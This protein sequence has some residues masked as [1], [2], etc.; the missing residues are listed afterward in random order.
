M[1]PILNK[2]CD[3][4]ISYDFS[5]L[6]K[7]K[8]FK[9]IWQFALDK[10]MPI[11]LMNIPTTYPAQSVDGF[12]ISGGGGGIF[13]GGLPENSVY[14]D[15]AKDVLIKNNYI[16]DVRLGKQSSNF[17]SITAY[18]DELERMMKSRTN[19]YIELA[20]QHSIGFGFLAYRA[21]TSLLYLA[22]SEIMK[23]LDQTHASSFK[24]LATFEW[25]DLVYNHFR[26][27]DE[28]LKSLFDNLQPKNFI[29]TSD[30]SIYL[31]HII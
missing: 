12:Y 1:H 11:G 23:L 30:H 17:S 29:L 27:L 6:S 10:N 26:V 22:M 25:S 24:E 3:F 7:A 15:S 5:N 20:K 2:F 14:P 16:F 19:S 28:C 4:D 13:Q 31:G 9:P 8:N 18:M 21:P